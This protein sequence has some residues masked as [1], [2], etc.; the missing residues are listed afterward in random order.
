[1]QVA[2]LT[3]NTRP[4]GGGVLRGNVIGRAEG[5][6]ITGSMVKAESGR[7]AEADET[8]ADLVAQVWEGPVS[9]LPGRTRSKWSPRTSGPASP[10]KSRN[11]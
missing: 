5:S 3:K 6:L 1:M 10:W 4:T 2:G 8:S 7:N 9:R 11:G